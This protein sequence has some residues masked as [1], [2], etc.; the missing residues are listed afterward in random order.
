MRNLCAEANIV[1]IPNGVDLAPFS[2]S[3]GR[4]DLLAATLIPKSYLL[5]M[6]RLKE[7]KGV[8]VLLRALSLL[9]ASTPIPLVIAGAG[10]EQ[11]ALEQLSQSLGLG[12]RVWFVGRRI[13]R[14]RLIC[15]KTPWPPWFHRAFGK[16]SV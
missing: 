15:F 13:I 1:N 14:P 5:F 4:P 3:A 6:G 8:D 12:E 16:R 7:R 2:R 11:P 9:S 10:E